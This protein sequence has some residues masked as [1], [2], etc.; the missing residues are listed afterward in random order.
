M[1]TTTDVT[2]TTSRTLHVEGVAEPMD[3]QYT[4][5]QFIPDWVTETLVEG[6]R[7][8]G[9]GTEEYTIEIRGRRLTAAGR[10][11]ATG[12]AE[13]RYSDRWG[14]SKLADLPDWVR[15]LLRGADGLRAGDN[16]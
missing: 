5:G 15:P 10:L 11:H 8:I 14:N 4:R 3:A 12:R 13:R 9:G 1:I 2:R 16:R 6:G 7:H